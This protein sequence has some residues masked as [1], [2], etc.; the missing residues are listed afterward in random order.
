M[1]FS[2]THDLVVTT[3][4]INSYFVVDMMQLAFFGTFLNTEN[5]ELGSSLWMH[6]S[7]APIFSVNSSFATR[8]ASF[9]YLAIIPF[10]NMVKICHGFAFDAREG[11]GFF[12]S[13]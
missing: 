1:T 9:F 11:V 2:V 7:F 3:A 10:E 5:H 4:S 12:I 13:R 8:N 6:E